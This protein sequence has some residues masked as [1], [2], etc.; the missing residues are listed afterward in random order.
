MSKIISM[1]E[2]AGLVADGD[3]IAVGGQ[4]LYRRPVAMVRELI[5]QG[6]RDLTV[7]GL[8]AGFETDILLASGRVTTVRS[9]YT[10]FD[11]LGLAPHFGRDPSVGIVEETEA[12]IIQ[13]AK[14]AMAYLGFLPFRGAIQTDLARVRPDLKTVTCPY[15]GE[16]LVAW[17]AIRPD[18]A[19]LH[20]QKADRHGN[21]VL[22][23]NPSIDRLWAGAAV[24]TVV[25][26]EEIVETIDAGEATIMG[27]DVTAVVHAPMGAHPTGCYPSYRIDV[28][29]LLD[30]LAAC[31][32]QR[33]VEWLQ[34]SLEPELPAY[35]DRFVAPNRQALEMEGAGA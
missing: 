20:A 30:Y 24:K 34:A 13:G 26:A 29:Y 32:E 22:S 2:A 25:T 4:T 6:R 17:P 8:T 12:S 16:A 11:F 18:V 3:M 1:A 7:V 23:S 27:R 31:R 9:G 33:A 15:T 35:V 21:A 28:P 5:R 19:L 14:A 10:G